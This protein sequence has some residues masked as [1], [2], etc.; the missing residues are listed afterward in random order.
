MGG[1]P[2]CRLD[3]VWGDGSWG[4]LVTR[5]LNRCR[6]EFLAQQRLS[7]HGQRQPS[8]GAGQSLT[9]DL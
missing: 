7:T 2:P 5:I 8:E 3:R 9:P 4:P 6:V 1:P